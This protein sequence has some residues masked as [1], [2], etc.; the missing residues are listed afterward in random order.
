[1]RM[2]WIELVVGVTVC[3]GTA[4]GQLRFGLIL[5]H[6]PS[7][8]GTGILEEF[9]RETSRVVSTPKLQIEWRN[10]AN[11]PGNETF[12]RLV[13]V[14]MTGECSL[15]QAQVEDPGRP[16]GITHVS[17]GR[18]LPFVEVNCTRIAT[19]MRHRAGVRP[20]AIDSG[21][22]GRALARVAA[23]EI[24]HVLSNRPDHDTGGLAKAALSYY[25]LYGYEVG[26]SDRTK[27]WIDEAL[28]GKPSSAAF[29]AAA[30]LRT[31]AK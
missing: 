20:P 3:T 6:P 1:M 21:I 7:L 31:G 28:D 9:K 24:Y 27:R 13:L 12:D 22:V 11:Y 16:L 15:D 18:I 29:T 17:D 5:N 19:L 4:T 2:N 25:D 8:E 23:H 26:F 10:G 30:H 14:R